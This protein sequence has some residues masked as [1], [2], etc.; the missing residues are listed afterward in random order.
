ME[1][2]MR[3]RVVGAVVLVI[4]GI[5]L[6]LLLARCLRADDA[7]DAQTTRV[8]EITPAGDARPAD[9]PSDGA[10]ADEQSAPTAPED[11]RRATTEGS[12]DDEPAAVAPTA[13]PVPQEAQEAS[14]PEPEPEAEPAPPAPNADSASS[15]E[16][17]VERTTS[18]EGW[19]VQIA[20]FGDESNAMA[21][22]RQLL[23]RYPAF[24][25][26]GRVGDDTYYRVRIGPFDNEA[27]ATAAAEELRQQGRST[28]VQRAE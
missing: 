28:L 19:V 22:A 4:L 15:D 10:G 14:P 5:L 7:G 1:D 13:P 26:E 24:Y 6:P 27:A 18:Q 2:V 11:D 9:Q 25:Q 8:Y 21:L 20:S 12:P 3:K 16:P 23:D 17:P